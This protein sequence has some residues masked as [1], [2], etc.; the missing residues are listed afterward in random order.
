MILKNKKAL[1]LS[2]LA[3][4]LPIPVALLLRE[5]LAERMTM[6]GFV[7]GIPVAML[8][9]HWLCILFT[10]LDKG[11]KNRNTKLMS[12]M[13]WI[14]PLITNLSV[15]GSYALVLGV[16]FSPVAWTLVPMGL[17]FVFIGNYMPKVRMNGTV[18]IKIRW[19]YSS[20]ANWNATH[21]FAGK[22]WVAGGFVMMLAALLPHIWAV[23]AM[24]AAIL[25]LCLVPMVYS[26]RFYR[27]E[28]AEGKPLNRGYRTLDRKGKVFAVVF[29]VLLVVFLSVV[30]FRG[31]IRYTYYE[32]YFVADSNMYSDNFLH[33]DVIESVEYREGDVPGLRVG[34]YGSFRLLL[35]W[36]E[37]EEFGTYIR[38]TYYKPE[39]CVVVRTDDLVFVL[40]G[41]TAEETQQI[42]Q[43]LLEKTG[44]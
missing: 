31:E 18:G 13:L 23:G 11:N 5:R 37:N 14:I 16:E 9:V 26:Y 29:T 36:F 34:G 27:R 3:I 15:L 2:S 43:T 30:L 17:L 12:L 28:K 38:Y 40:S 33:Y 7:W 24:L 25:M 1:I 6:N 22:V 35:G 21:R 19:T 39:A 10:G 4:L 8:A 41:E 44:K 42:Y 20:E 32:D